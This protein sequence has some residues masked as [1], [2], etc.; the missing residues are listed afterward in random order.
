MWSRRIDVSGSALRGSDAVDDGPE[1]FGFTDRPI[2]AN[3]P[4]AVFNGITPGWL[5]TLG[6]P[7]LAGRDISDRDGPG[8]PRVAL[9]NQA[10]A[11]K[12]LNG[13]N[14]VGHTIHPT[15]QPGSPLIEV[16]GLVADAVYRDVREATLPTAYVPLTQSVDSSLVEDPTVTAPAAV[17]LSVRAASGQPGVLTKS[18]AA[19]IGQVNPTLAVTFEPLDGRVSATLTRERLLAILSAAFGV[20][21]LLMASIGLYGLTCYAVSLRRVE[22]GIRMALGAT[23]GSVIALVLGR[24]SWLI[25]GGVVAG[26][27]LAVWASRF[28]STLLYGLEPD[29]PATLLAAVATLGFIAA[30]AGWLPANRVSRLDPT[31][32]LHD[33]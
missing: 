25:G 23:R 3:A 33:V 28:V 10:F 32:V 14:P 11:R 26:L 19:A 16:V 24:V 27:A 17:T 12:F 2:P 31:Q 18:V 20:L 21:A 15:K 4:L 6:M 22:I 5:A 30:F 9:V 8:S 1:G 29:D 13:A 7:L